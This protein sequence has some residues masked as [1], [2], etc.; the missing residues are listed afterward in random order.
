MIETAKR[1]GQTLQHCVV[2]VPGQEEANVL[3]ITPQTEHRTA[4]TESPTC[5]HCILI[6]GITVMIIL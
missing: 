5:E 2:Y 4:N 3:H 6:L 1:T